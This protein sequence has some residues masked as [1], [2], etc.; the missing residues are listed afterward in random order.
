A[1]EQKLIEEPD[2]EFRF[3]SGPLVN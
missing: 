1:I 3:H 2:S